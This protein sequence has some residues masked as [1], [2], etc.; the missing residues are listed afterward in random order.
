MDAPPVQYVRT[1]D[2]FD[3]AYSVTG[4]GRPLVLL[5]WLIY[6]IRSLWSSRRSWMEGLASRFRFVQLDFRG[7]G[8]SSRGLSPG[9][10]AIDYVT[11]LSAVVDELALEH[12]VLFGVGGFGH[13]AVRYAVVQ[14]DRVAALVLNTT[15]VSVARFGGGMNALA[16]ENW[17]YFVRLNLPPGLDAGEKSEWLDRWLNP[18]THEDWKIMAPASMASN[19]EADLPRLQTPTLV[20]H[21]NGFPIFGPSESI[22]LAASIPNARFVMIEGPV[23]PPP[24]SASAYWMSA[25]PSKALAALDASLADLAP[26]PDNAKFASSPLPATGSLSVRE[27]EVLRLIAAGRSNSQIAEELVISL[28]TVQRH[29]SNILA[30]TGAAN[31]TEAAVY[32]RDKGLV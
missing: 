18:A 2:G 6:D 28:N 22:R 32:A 16:A 21:S 12:F 10:G 24:G 1:S 9:H 30:K 14:P 15:P 31:R 7:R 20:L 23:L 11:D 3:I 4:T 8:L 5:P 25:D 26:A 29:V 17:E 27:L 19:I 13:T